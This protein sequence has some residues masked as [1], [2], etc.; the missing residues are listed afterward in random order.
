MSVDFIG[1]IGTRNASETIP[2]QGPIID[3]AHIA[4]VAKAHDENGF[5]RALIAFHSTSPESIL[6]AVCVGMADCEIFGKRRFPKMEEDPEK[7][8]GLS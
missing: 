6:V 7:F 3:L 1:F 2:P 8:G 4:R 5:D